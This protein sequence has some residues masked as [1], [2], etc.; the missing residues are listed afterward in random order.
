LFT[1]EMP[2][3]LLTLVKFPFFPKCPPSICIQ[4]EQIQRI[5]P[6]CTPMLIHF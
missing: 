3:I 6:C 2:L 5:C 4:R 1:L